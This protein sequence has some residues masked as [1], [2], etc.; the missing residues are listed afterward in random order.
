M[1]R[2]MFSAATGMNA[3]QLNVDTIA[4]NLANVN[5]TGY[6]KSRADFQDLLYQTLRQ[7]GAQTTAGVE[8]PVGIQIGHGVRASAVAKIFSQGSLIQTKKDLDLVIQGRG[9]FQV[10]LPT[11]DIAYTRDGS[12]NRDST[13]QLVTADGYQ[14]QP[15]ITIPEDALVVTVSSDGTVSA[16]QPSTP[17]PANLGTIELAL[18]SNPTGL[19]AR[20]GRNLYLET[21]AS[22]APITS[23]PG[24]ADGAGTIDN[25]YLENSNVQLVEE[26]LALIIAQRAYEANSKVIQTSDQMLQMA[27]TMRR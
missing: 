22:G 11:G 23:Q 6:K 12:F 4:N 7:P 13:G 21:T 17:D 14:L 24:G 2:A 1:M 15:S 19:D 16:T 25:G 26:I 27:N 8:M 5:T 10:L 3:Q 9:F 18:F 20:Y